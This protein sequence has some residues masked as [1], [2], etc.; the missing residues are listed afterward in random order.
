MFIIVVD[1]GGWQDGE[2]R[3]EACHSSRGKQLPTFGPINKQH[4]L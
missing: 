4:D 3:R 2:V 1:D